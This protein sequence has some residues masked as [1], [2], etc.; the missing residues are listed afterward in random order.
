MQNKPTLGYWKIRGLVSTIRYQLA[1]SKVDYEMKEYDAP[2][3]WFS[4]KPTL[5]LDFPNIPHWIDGDFKMTEHM[6]IH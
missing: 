1:Y 3:K 4:V 6:A 5:G 2:E